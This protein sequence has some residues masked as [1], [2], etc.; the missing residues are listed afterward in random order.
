MLLIAVLF[1]LL[2]LNIYNSLF[3]LKSSRSS[4]L[5]VQPLPLN[6][7]VARKLRA[8]ANTLVTTSTGISLPI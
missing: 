3:V 8:H 2:C 5:I 7:E 4:G 1:L 6:S